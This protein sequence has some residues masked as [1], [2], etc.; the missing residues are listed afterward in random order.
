RHAPLPARA[1]RGRLRDAALGRL[2]RGEGGASSRGCRV[3]ALA[4]AS[5]ER[6]AALRLADGEA[7]LWWL[8]QSTFLLR[9]RSATVF[10]D[11]YLA[12]HPD[13]LVPPAFAPEDARG[14]DVVAIRHAHLD[15]LG[16]A[17]RPGTPAA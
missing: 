13:R 16:A 17:S 12:P 2:R 14:L 10:V 9:F 5:V 1:A 4:A 3:T 15:H 11:P 7:A 6:L 8:G